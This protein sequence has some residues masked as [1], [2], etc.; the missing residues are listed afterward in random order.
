MSWHLNVIGYASIAV[1]VV[2]ALWALKVG[3]H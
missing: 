3:R 2:M 1:L